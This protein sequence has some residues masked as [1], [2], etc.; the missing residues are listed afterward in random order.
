MKTNPT[1]LLLTICF[2]LACCLKSHAQDFAYTIDNGTI[3]ITGYTGPGGA[4]TIPDTITGLPVVSIAANAFN[5][6]PFGNGLTS[7]TIGNNVINIGNRAFIASSA[8]TNVS[9]GNSVISIGNAAF[10][11]CYYLANVTL[12]NSVLT[13]GEDAFSTC[14]F[15]SFT[16]PNNVTN[17]GNGAFADCKSLTN[18]IIPNHVTKIGSNVFSGCANLVSVTIPPSVISLEAGAFRFCESLDSVSIPNSVTCIGDYAFSACDALTGITVPNSVISIGNYAFAYCDALTDITIPDSVVS[19]GDYAF[20]FCPLVNVTIPNSVI[21]LGDAVFDFCQSLTNVSIGNN[22]TSIGYDTFNGCINLSNVTIGNNVTNIGGQAFVYCLGLYTIRIPDSVAN[23]GGWAFSSCYNLTNVSIGTNV[24]SIGESAFNSC[25]SLTSIKVP[26]NVST[27]GY[28]AFGNCSGMT[29]ISVEATNAFFSSTN[30][31]LFD[32]NQTT[33]VQ[34]PEGKSGSYIIPNS[35]TNIGSEAFSACIGLTNIIVPNSVT[36]IGD[37]AFSGCENLASVRVGNGVTSIGSGAFLENHALKSIYF[38]GNAPAIGSGILQGASNS[39]VYYLLGTAGWSSIFA[40]RPTVLEPG[41]I[42]YEITINNGAVTITRY[43]GPGGALSVPSTING[44]PVVSIGAEAFSGGAY[45]TSVTIPDSVV[46]IGAY[47][48]N[49]SIGLTSV[50]LGTN[51]SVIGDYAFQACSSLRSLTIPSSVTTIG[52]SAFKYCTRLTSLYFQGNAPDTGE[53][54][55]DNT[56]SV[57]NYYRAGTTGWSSLFSDRPTALWS[58]STIWPKRVAGTVN[59]DNELSIGMTLDNQGNCYLTGWFDGV[60]D[61]GGVVLANRGAEGQDIFVVK[62]AASGALQWA[63]RAGT[64]TPYWNMGRGIGVDANGNVYVTGGFRGD[65]DFGTNIISAPD[66]TEFFLTKY[67]SNGVVQW[68]RQST[69]GNPLESGVYG[70]GLAVDNAG[71]SYALL[72]AGNGATIT[73]GTTNLLNPNSTGHS[74][75][76][77]KYNNAGALQWAQLLIA[78][79]RVYAT[80]VALDSSGNIYVRGAYE[81]G[82]AKNMFLSKYSNSGNLIWSRQSSGARVDEGGVA[83]DPSG[84]VYVTGWFDNAPV[85]FGGI[86]LTNAGSYD[87]FVAKYNSSGTPQWAR[88]AGGPNPDIYFDVALD[89]QGNV[90]P[91]GALGSGVTSPN[92]TGSAMVAKYD[93]DGTL[94]WDYSASGAAGN[95]F[96]SLAAKVAVDS[97]GNCFLAGWYQTATAFGTNVLQ[98]QSYWNFFLTKLTPSGSLPLMQTADPSF[99]VQTNRFGFTIT[100]GINSVVVVEACTNLINPVWLPLQTNTLNSGSA[101]FSDP[102]WTSYTGRFYRLRAP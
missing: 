60:N 36:S 73:L 32:K 61:F 64:D 96:S 3:I 87:A 86:T 11:A 76:L 75:I 68:V 20:N 85:S 89:A 99:G 47:A 7:V 66:S 81:S 79:N 39:V 25:R 59:P 49:S 40:G 24:G 8:L 52:N 74:T 84:N 4:V 95:P 5:G 29:N 28:R 91:V 37:L 26:G 45:I 44:L 51:V 102:E 82:P 56:S 30:G 90:Y 43:T 9:I 1:Q 17:I 78:P 15:T 34:C 69:G 67:N 72:F 100:G 31:V 57:L 35:V 65:A 2:L 77:A 53:N 98:P 55:F 58:W 71:N 93:P 6:F 14:Y 23:I 38:Q 70:T 50:W 19:I 13:I 80:K 48:F 88:R 83:V 46:T 10:S 62:Y 94:Q 16:I 54:V 101:Y 12:P 18:I 21:S 33:L 97:A 92:G 22:V 63:S 42:D 27:I 41:Q